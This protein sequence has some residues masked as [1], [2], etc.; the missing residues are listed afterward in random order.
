MMKARP[1]FKPASDSWIDL[2]ITSFEESFSAILFMIIPG[3]ILHDQP[4]PEELKTAL[5]I[6]GAYRII[7]NIAVTTACRKLK[8]DFH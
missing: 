1:D 4:Q 2:D 5:K 3:K 7:L 8:R 6:T